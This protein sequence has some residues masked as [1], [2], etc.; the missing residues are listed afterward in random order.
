MIGECIENST[1]KTLESYIV[2]EVAVEVEEKNRGKMWGGLLR[3]SINIRDQD[4]LPL[5]VFSSSS[6]YKTKSKACKHPPDTINPN[7]LETISEYI[8][9]RET[10]A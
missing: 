2:H 1:E 8:P 7:F 4:R 9:S 10:P 6:S 5:C 3:A